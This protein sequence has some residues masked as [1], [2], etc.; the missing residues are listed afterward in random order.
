MAIV[1]I[2]TMQHYDLCSTLAK[3]EEPPL[4]KLEVKNT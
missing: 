4:A 2:V 3:S 1:L